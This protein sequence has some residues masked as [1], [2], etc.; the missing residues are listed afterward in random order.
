M[1]KI[2]QIITTVVGIIMSIG[3]F[4]QAYK[5]YKTKSAE[6]ISLAT[7]VIFALGTLIWTLY[8]FF[9]KD[10]VL[11]LSFTVGVIG[12]WLVLFLSIKYK[13][14]AKKELGD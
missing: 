2:F 4:P 14:K 7:F 11:I 5:I 9:I 12:S 1:L 8:G 6:N 3:Y 13:I 10:Y